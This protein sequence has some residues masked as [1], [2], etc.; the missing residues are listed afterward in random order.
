MEQKNILIFPCGTAVALEMYDALKYNSHFRI[1]GFS[2][3]MDYTDYLYPEGM[4]LYTDERLMIFHPEFEKTIAELI[5][6]FSIEFI[7]PSFDDVA[8]K[9]AKIADHLSAKVVTSP[10][11]TAVAAR[12]KRLMYKSLDGIIPVPL[13]FESPQSVEDFP[14][15]FKPAKGC[16]SVGAM[17]V[18]DMEQLTSCVSKQNDFVICE[19]LPGEEISVDCFTDRHGILRFIGPRMFVVK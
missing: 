6:R 8:E 5:K 2:A 9:L 14:V 13:T 7:I 19:Y 16:G 12:D 3:K 10:Y 4:Y 15:F 18:N 1:Y 17:L 11:K